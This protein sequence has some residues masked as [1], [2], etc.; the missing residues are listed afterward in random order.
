MRAL[1][2]YLDQLVGIP[3]AEEKQIALE[4]PVA[5]VGE[6]LVKGTCH[7]CHAAT[8]PNP[9]PEE[10]LQGAIPPLGVLL[11]RVGP[12][13]FVQKVRLG[14]P[15]TMGQLDQQYRGRMPVFYYLTPDEAA[16]AY[17]YLQRYPP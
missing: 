11:K 2:A 9:T 1:V 5:H 8:G 16:A 10:I 7:I 15:I 3:N 14:R 6:D 12:Q 17:V 13:Q 4:I